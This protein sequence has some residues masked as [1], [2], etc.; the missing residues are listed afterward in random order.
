[1]QQQGSEGVT[2]GRL[3]SGVNGT[4]KQGR[5]DA[6]AAQRHDRPVMDYIRWYTPLLAVS[7]RPGVYPALS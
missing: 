5:G 1:M 3:P 6:G 4:D 7:V 2:K